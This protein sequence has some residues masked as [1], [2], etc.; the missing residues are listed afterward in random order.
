MK[1][2]AIL[3][4]ILLFTSIEAHAK[5]SAGTALYVRGD[6]LVQQHGTTTTI[7]RGTKLFAGDTIITDDRSRVKMKMIDGSIIYVGRDS[8]IQVKDYTSKKE[9]L[10]RGTFNMLWGKV[11]FVVSKLKGDASFS[12]RTTTAV[13]GVRGTDFAVIKAQ[14]LVAN[15]ALNLPDTRTRLGVFEG[16]VLAKNPISGLEQLIL[17]GSGADLFPNGEL[18]PFTGVKLNDFDHSIQNVS[19]GNG[20]QTNKK[21]KQSSG[22]SS[23]QTEQA[24]N[25][26]SRTVDHEPSS[27]ETTNKHGTASDQ[28]QGK[29][30]PASEPADRQTT[31]PEVTGGEVANDDV[32]AQRA[33]GNASS[34]AHQEIGDRH[35]S[36]GSADFDLDN[37]EGTDGTERLHQGAVTGEPSLD[38]FD[39]SSGQQQLE[40]TM[41]TPGKKPALDIGISDGMPANMMPG[42]PNSMEPGAAVGMMPRIPDGMMPGMAVGMLPGIPDGMVFDVVPEIST[43]MMPG[44]PVGTGFPGMADLFIPSAFD[45]SILAGAQPIPRNIRI[46][47]GFVAP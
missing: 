23:Q 44:M 43:G 35:A 39:R 21:R 8:R 20:E 27:E 41:H 26:S 33:S 4:I 28:G 31:E 36:E 14:P 24:D 17:H 11:R 9:S 46:I 40:Q 15:N 38:T 12:V 19:E 13:L 47:P 6:A 18:N 7:R 22:S 16:G 2:L 3:I 5:P 45:P 37:I 25:G 32:G 10:L 1:R 30:E 34:T 42:I 29:R